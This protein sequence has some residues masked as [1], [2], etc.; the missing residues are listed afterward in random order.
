VARRSA[1]VDAAGWLFWLIVF[2]ALVV[3]CVVGAL[4]LSFPHAPKT[5]P[6]ATG[7]VVAA[8]ASGA[9]SWAVNSMLQYRKKRQRVLERKKVKKQR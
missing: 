7:V 2:A 4:K 5:V 3:P 1:S 9:V 8:L 6:V